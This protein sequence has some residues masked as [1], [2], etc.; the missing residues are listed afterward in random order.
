MGP[1]CPCFAA[2]ELAAL[3]VMLAQYR[4]AG[5]RKVNL[6]AVAAHLVRILQLGKQVFKVLRGHQ[7]TAFLLCGKTVH[8]FLKTF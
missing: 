8:F 2:I 5:P 7:V 4:V 6:L 3:T 1:Y